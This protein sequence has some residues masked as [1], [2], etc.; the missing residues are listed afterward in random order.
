MTTLTYPFLATII[1]LRV[2]VHTFLA[3]VFVLMKN[4]AVAAL[5]HIA[6]NS[7]ETLMLASTVIL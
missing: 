3:V 6:A 7:V 4:K 5:A 2:P 1:L